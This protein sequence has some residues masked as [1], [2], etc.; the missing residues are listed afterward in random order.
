[1]IG[2]I[3]VISVLFVK[4]IAESATTADPRGLTFAGSEVCVSCHV[5]ISNNYVHNNHYNTSEAFSIN[6]FKRLIKAEIKSVAY[7]NGQTVSVEERGEDV[8]QTLYSNTEKLGSERLDITF[9][10]GSNAQTFGYWKDDQVFQLPLTYLADSATWTNSPGFS[11]DQPYYTRVIPSRCFECHS[12]FAHAGKVQTGPMELSEKFKKNAIV[13]GIDCERCHGP[14]F[15]HVQFHQSNPDEK[16]ARNIISVKLLS[17]QQQLDMCATCHSGDPLSL[18]SIFSFKPGDT[19]S[20][21]YMHFTGSTGEPDVHGKQMQLLAMSQCFKQSTLTCIT[22]H[23][24]HTKSN[25]LVQIQ[26]CVS[27]HQP[28][29]HPAN[30]AMEKQDCISCH[31]PLRGSKSLDFKNLDGSSIK[32][33]LRTHR[34]GIYPEVEWK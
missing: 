7:N 4:C 6:N 10:S 29:K 17:R 19:L 26:Q 2:G 3:I 31:M 1:M 18:K 8:F 27:C 12:S 14:A 9:G 30:I 16:E 21:Y 23:D 28:V 22:C 15:S 25:R 24:P 20:K 32:Y 13:F 33:L 5:D 34:I 11:V